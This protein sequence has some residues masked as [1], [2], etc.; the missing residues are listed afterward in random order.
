MDQQY[1]DQLSKMKRPVP[2]SSLTNDA[3]NPLP[4]ERPP[5]FTKKKD[6]L[7][8]LFQRMTRPGRYE[9]IIESVARG[10]TITEMSQVILMEGFRRGKWNPDLFL[11]LIEP[12]MYMIMALCER[13]G[14]SYKVDREGDP[15]SEDIKGQLDKKVS[16]IKGSIKSS[17]LKSGVL[18]KSIEDAIETLPAEHI[19]D[20]P[21]EEAANVEGNNL[22]S[23][24]G[25]LLAAPGGE[26]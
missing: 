11:M 13:A 26:V 2:G 5:N 22:N 21:I 18:P 19:S 20:R 14:V 17:K 7:E 25:S 24:E 9:N 23:G 4:F 12:T 8:D 16:E 15:S 6:A 10:T 3:D 1:L